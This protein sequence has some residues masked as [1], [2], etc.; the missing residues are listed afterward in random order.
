MAN[1][2][3]HIILLRGAGALY[4]AQL[5]SIPLSIGANF[6]AGRFLE[7]GDYGA[8]FTA[9]FLVSFIALISNG[10]LVTTLIREP[11]TVSEKDYAEAFVYQVVTALI[12]GA[13]Y[14]ACAGGLE[15]LFS[16]GIAVGELR[17]MLGALALVPLLQAFITIPLVRLER[18]VNYGRIAKLSLAWAFLERVVLL[19]LMFAG[20]RGFSYVF[21]RVFGAFLQAVSLWAVTRWSP[22]GHFR[23]VLKRGWHGS[24]ALSFGAVFQLRSLSNLVQTS[25]IPGLGNRLFNVQTVGLLAWS[26]NTAY[27]LG[28]TLPQSLGRVVV[29]ANSRFS[30]DRAGYLRGVEQA[31]RLCTFFSSA[32][33]LIL[34]SLLG[35]VLTY[36]FH[37]KW[38]EARH[39]FW[40]AALPMI[41]GVLLVIY[42][43]L[44]LASGRVFTTAL[45]NWATACFIFLCCLVGGYK[46]GP[47][48]LLSGIIVG[49]FLPSVLYYFITRREFPLRLGNCFFIPATWGA[50]GALLSNLLKPYFVHGL[51]SL[52]AFGVV[53]GAATS[54]SFLIAHP[55]DAR[56]LWHLV[57][58]RLGPRTPAP[59]LPDTAGPR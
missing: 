4:F 20:A 7:P 38:Y 58:G 52:V 19:A 11:G 13:L 46:F 42:D 26:S 31:L 15:K 57:K 2:P 1:K 5:F 8:F 22:V 25:V 6:L 16:I 54:A 45:V 37:P 40:L 29:G 56:D 39:F 32:L 34:A 23:Y 14:V 33:L 51:F 27:T 43:A 36:A 12:L 53:I 35:E 24:R 48:G 55:D 30:E 59:T 49:N 9:D 10:G 18:E 28:Q 17:G 21:A 44:T 3:E 41:Q 50:A 47:M